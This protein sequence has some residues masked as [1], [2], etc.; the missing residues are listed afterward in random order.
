MYVII[1]KL[2]KTLRSYNPSSAL[3]TRLLEF[4]VVPRVLQ[5]LFRFVCWRCRKS[6]IGRECGIRRRFG[7][8]GDPAASCPLE[9]RYKHPNQLNSP[10]NLTESEVLR[11]R[12]YIARIMSSIRSSLSWSSLRCFNMIASRAPAAHSYGLWF[13]S[14][15]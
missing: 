3:C 6:H 5:F 15:P 11:D 13:K 7:I 2:N 10:V 9:H 8:G 4:P 1:H 12:G 14:G